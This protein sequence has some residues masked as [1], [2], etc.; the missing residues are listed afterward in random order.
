[1]IHMRA[2]GEQSIFG[3]KVSVSLLAVTPSDKPSFPVS[4][5]R[6]RRIHKKLEQRCGPQFPPKPA[7]FRIGDSFVMHPSLWAELRRVFRNE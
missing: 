3:M 5:H 4:R 7:C 1:M 6:S 2:R